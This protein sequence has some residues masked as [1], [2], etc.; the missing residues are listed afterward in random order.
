MTQIID[1]SDWDTGIVNLAC[2]QDSWKS[3]VDL[4][5]LWGIIGSYVFTEVRVGALR[6]LHP[7]HVYAWHS[8]NF[9]RVWQQK[10]QQQ[11][12]NAG[13]KTLSTSEALPWEEITGV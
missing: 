3:L 11:G 9:L 1:A 5:E 13:K 10:P 12:E 7:K 2:E 6:W 8:S 4:V